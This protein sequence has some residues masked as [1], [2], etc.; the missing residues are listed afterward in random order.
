MSSSSLSVSDAEKISD[1]LTQSLNENT[2]ATAVVTMADINHN[3]VMA[4]IMVGQEEDGEHLGVAPDAT[5]YSCITPTEYTI[6]SGIEWLI[7]SGVNIINASIGV[8]H[9]GNYSS[10]DAWIDHIAVQHDVHFISVSGN[11]LEGRRTKVTSPGMAYNVIT[12]GGFDA[13]NSTNILD[14]TVFSDSLYD[15]VSNTGP[16]KPNLVA[17]AAFCLFYENGTSYAAPQVTGVIAQLCSCSSTLKVKQSAIGA[18]LA[19]SSARKIESLGSGEKGDNFETDSRIE[20][21]PQIS[22]IEGAGI[23]DARWARHIV[24]SGNYWT[25]IVYSD[26][27]PYT[28]TVT[29]D[30]T[31]NTVSR[32]AIFWLK[33]NEVTSHTANTSITEI[34]IGNLD[35]YVYDPNGVQIAS[36]TI[37]GGNFEIVQFT[38]TVT[39]EYTIRINSDS[40]D[41]EYIGISLW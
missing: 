29:I 4:L 15:E 39:G 36:S 37:D 7:D 8:N 27:F 1:E 16:Q 12:V 40:I 32:I 21:N 9:G 11:L 24:A 13:N 25:P 6:Y 17:N 5:L 19:A 18:I 38:P 22:D 35:L 28:R 26:N 3:T 2:T 23:L 20:G 31:A 14:F 33:R 41:K 10:L 30:A 34:P